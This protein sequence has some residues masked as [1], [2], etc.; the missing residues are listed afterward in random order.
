MNDVDL[1]LEHATR[2]MLVRR[3]KLISWLSLAWMT[4]EAVIGVLAGVTANSIALIGARYCH[5]GETAASAAV[6]ARRA[7]PSV[8]SGAIVH[9]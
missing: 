1:S 6:E 5:T 9:H 3:V 7:I 2:V 8:G 4:A